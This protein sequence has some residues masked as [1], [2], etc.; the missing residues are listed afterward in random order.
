M[1]R[2]RLSWST[3]VWRMVLLAAMC[4]IIPNPATASTAQASHSR[5]ATASARSAAP[6]AQTAQAMTDPSPRTDRRRA[7]KSAP[8]SAPRP[9]EPTRNPSVW[10]PPWSTSVANI[11]I[12]TP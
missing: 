12:S 11:G 1:T 4:A 3:M 7:R 6:N 8:P 5:R 9:M 2:P 10:A